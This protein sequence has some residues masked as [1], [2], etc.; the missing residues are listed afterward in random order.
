MPFSQTDIYSFLNS[1]YQIPLLK[2]ELSHFFCSRS[3]L[4]ES[5]IHTAVHVLGV[6][7]VPSWVPPGDHGDEHA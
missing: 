6:L 2:S 3:L 1:A 7:G 4:P 5:T